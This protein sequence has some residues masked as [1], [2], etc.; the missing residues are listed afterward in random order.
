MKPPKKSDRDNPSKAYAQ[1]SGIALQML[2]IIGVGTF[3]GVQLDKYLETENNGFT[4][5]LSLLSVLIA[6][7]YVVRQ[8]IQISKKDDK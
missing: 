1:Y 7:F 3:V 6:V 2:V 4:A 8:I 5:G